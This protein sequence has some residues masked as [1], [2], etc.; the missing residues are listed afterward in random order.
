MSGMIFIVDSMASVRRSLTRLLNAA[1]F[2]VVTFESGQ[3]FVDSASPESGDFI[4]LDSQTTDLSG[5]EVLGVLAQ[6]GDPSQTIMTSASES[7]NARAH[8]QRSGAIAY[9]SKPVDGSALIDCIRFAQK[10]NA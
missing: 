5:L 7:P 1:G 10:G 9:F 4:V 6:R 3:A 8:A 2:C